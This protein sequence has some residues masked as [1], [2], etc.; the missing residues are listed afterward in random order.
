MI[1]MILRLF[2]SLLAVCAAGLAQTCTSI[3][4]SPVSANVGVNGSTG[5]T[6]T[7]TASP[8]GCLRTATSNNDWITLT[9]STGASGTQTL[10][11]YSVAAN[12]STQSRT[13][14][15]SVN[16][17][18]GTFTVIQAAQT[19]TYSLQPQTDT[20]G[21]SGGSGSF[22]LL[23]NAACSWTATASD[24]W[25]TI[26]SNSSGAGNGNIAYTVAPNPTNGTRTATIAVGTATFTI[27]ETA[28]CSFTLS[29]AFSTI[30]EK[31]TTGSLSVTANSNSCART[32]ASDVSWM[33][34]SSGASGTGNGTVGYSIQANTTPTSRTGHI[35]ILDSSSNVLAT[36]T[37]T[38][39][40]ATCAYALVP[41]SKN[42]PSSG[43]SGTFSLTTTCSWTVTVSDPWIVFTS[44]ASGTGNFTF[45]YS[46]GS[47][48]TAL[49]RNGSIAVGTNL[50]YISQDGATCNITLPS[51]SMDA[52]AAG[53]TGAITVNAGQGCNWTASSN[54]TWLTIN[55][56]A[57]GAGDG[58][59]A[60]I[61]APNT[62]TV[63]RTGVITIGNKLFTVTQGG[64]TCDYAIAPTSASIASGPFNANINVTTTCNWTA[65]P[66]VSW[67]SITS[68]ATT[69]TGNGTVSYSVGSNP[70]SQSRSG[71]I[72][73]ASQTFSLTQAG[74]ACAVT[75]APVS[76][77]VSGPASSGRFAVT[78][79]N[80]GC[81]WKATSSAPWIIISG[82]SSI[83][84]SG[85]VDFAVETNPNVSARTGTIAVGT[86]TF[87][88]TQA[89]SVPAIT[90]AGVLNAASFLGGAVAPGEI[91]TIFGTFIGTTPLTTLQL[92]DAKTGIMN[93]LG[94]TR[95][96][97]D[98]VAAPMVY[99]SAAQTSAIV[100]YSVAGKT[101]TSMVVEY[102]GATSSA[103]ILNVAA[104]SPAIFSLDQSGKGPGAVLNQDFTLNSAANAAVRN[105]IIQIFATGE[106]P[107][108]P[109]GVDGKL[110]AAPLTVPSQTVTVRIG[111]IDAP[112]I[113]RGGAP[114]L[115]AGV[116]QINARVPL[117]APIGAAIPI[118][119]RVGNID[120]AAGVTIAVK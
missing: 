106:G 75:L 67:I 102:Q 25:V 119:V 84:G 15:I 117:T 27:T 13:G 16:G 52:P 90:A 17:G 114:G 12:T 49:K 50:F 54:A 99:S 80:S 24:P 7:V 33:T 105:T 55:G 2:I 101:T 71:A 100:P 61:A 68:G 85:A 36:F 56:S 10:I 48:P 9:S 77:S 104:A 89:G 4:L 39:N 5:L 21:G 118:V 74:A 35:N 109:A 65:V 34:I 116:I 46:V 95:V 73:I 51:T 19:C 58:N 62:T 42:Y 108:T 83:N 59:V 69:A 78:G 82:Y 30:L 43:G 18:L 31:A 112:V 57:G 47:N 64:A 14:T 115:V 120:S 1:L 97:F 41:T 29:P 8:S 107:T 20:I 111:N 94:A 23:T 11:I 40:G 26:T 53:A 45:S 96:L 28:A 79:S 98:G 91:V 37:V 81:T 87:T 22:S 92:N 38:Q 110:A 88:I 63:P 86:E 60:Y 72:K 66:S 44:S 113:Y 6:F 76:N 32:A 70:T 103:V 93:S 3:S